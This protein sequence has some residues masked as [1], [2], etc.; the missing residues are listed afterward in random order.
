[1][2]TAASQQRPV[3]LAAMGEAGQ[4]L[5]RNGLDVNGRAG[6]ARWIWGDN[7]QWLCARNRVL[8]LARKLSCLGSLLGLCL[9]PSPHR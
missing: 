8:L 1:M 3:W 9:L 2:V 7:E 6:W 5:R 4:T